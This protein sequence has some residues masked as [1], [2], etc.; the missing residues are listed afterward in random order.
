MTKSY[1]FN[2]ILVVWHWGCF[3]IKEWTEEERIKIQNHLDRSR[4]LF[5]THQ[6]TFSR[7]EKNKDFDSQYNI[8]DKE[9]VT[10]LKSLT[11]DDCIDIRPN[12]NPRY[13]NADLF[14]FQKSVSLLSYGE[15][16]NIRLYIKSYIIDQNDMEMVIVISFH[17]EGKYG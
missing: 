12:D 9:K 8:L 5:P 6:Y 1:H 15:E 11:V 13:P 7:S 10:I 14:I 17:E 3:T 16:E 2:I 4:A